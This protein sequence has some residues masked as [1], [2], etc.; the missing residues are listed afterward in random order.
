MLSTFDEAFF[1]LCALPAMA[2]RRYMHPLL[3]S[4][5]P[6][7]YCPINPFLGTRPSR[8]FSSGQPPSL[9][10]WHSSHHDDSPRT[11]ASTPAPLTPQH[12]PPVISLQHAVVFVECYGTTTQLA[13]TDQPCIGTPPNC[14]CLRSNTVVL[15]ME[16]ST[17]WESGK[18]ER[19]MPT[20]RGWIWNQHPNKTPYSVLR[21]LPRNDGGARAVRLGGIGGMTPNILSVLEDSPAPAPSAT[22]AILRTSWAG[23]K[24]GFA[25]L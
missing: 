15:R 5:S 1:P 8:T 18:A 10:R 24:S 11:A 6:F 19:S 23:D 14:Q 21:I 3:L 13:S 2:I 20:V 22:Y 7:L 4:S 12:P 17:A 9:Q 25:R 16:Y